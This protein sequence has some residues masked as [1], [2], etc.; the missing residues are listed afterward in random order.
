VFLFIYLFIISIYFGSK[1]VFL[2]TFKNAVCL[3]PIICRYLPLLPLLPL[4]P[5]FCPL[6]RL[7]Y[8]YFTF[9]KPFSFFSLSFLFA[10][11][12]F[13]FLFFIFSPSQMTSTNYFPFTI[14]FPPSSFLLLIFPISFSQEERVSY[15]TGT[16]IY[17]LI[18]L[19]T[20]VAGD[21]VLTCQMRFQ[22]FEETLRRVPTAKSTGLFKSP[23]QQ[24]TKR[25][26][27]AVP[28]IITSAVREV[29][30]RGITEVHYIIP[31]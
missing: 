12:L 31:L 2:I 15:F 7:F 5:P 1:T 17:P 14:T 8:F 4:C 3:F 24:T 9:T 25:E 29:E 16:R 30:R 21:L 19:A 13:L 23:I 18:Y 28:F 10:F 26:K 6:P 11:S 22:P 27:R 20:T